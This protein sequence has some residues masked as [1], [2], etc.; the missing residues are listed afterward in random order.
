MVW[1]IFYGGKP[2]R[3][4]IAA[5]IAMWALEGIAAF[6]Q[7]PTCNGKNVY[8]CS[9]GGTLLVLSKPVDYTLNFGS[10]ISAGGG[11]TASVLSDPKNPGFAATATVALQ[12]FGPVLPSLTNYTFSLASVGDQPTIAGVSASIACGVTG[13]AAYSFTLVTPGGPL[14]LKCPHMAGSGTTVT[15]KGQISFAPQKSFALALTLS[16]MA[17]S[18]SDML[19]LGAVSAQV[20][21]PCGSTV[22]PS[23]QAF[24][25]SGGSG[26][27]NITIGPGCAWGVSGIP[28]WVTPTNGASGTGNGKFS[29]QVAADAGADRTA[30][31]TVANISVALE[32]E[33]A[34]IPGL[35]PVGSLAQLASEG[36]WN[37]ELDA[38]NLGS[39]AA[40]VRLDFTDGNGSPLLLPLTF[41]QLAPAPTP[42]LAATL[43]RTIKPNARIVIDSPGPASG[44]TALLGSGQLLSTGSV[45]GF[46]IFSYPALQWNALVP[47]ETRNASTYYLPFDNTGVLATGV[48][49][50]NITA[51][52]TNIQV[53]I[54]NDAGAPI[55]TD[56]I[57]LT[58]QGYQQFMLNARYAQ[59][60]DLRGT[61]QFHTASGGQI[62]VL[63]VRANG[64]ALTTLPV[65][66]N[67][68]SPGGS[69]SQVTY[70]GGFTSTFYLVNTGG[71]PSSFTLSFF[72]QSGNPENVPLS[73]PQSGA[74][75]ST[76]ALTQTLAAGQMLQV[77]TQAQDAA[78]NISGSAQL[79]TT[80][81]I[82]GFEI[83]RWDTYGQE[84]S[85]PLETRTPGSFVLVF[86]NTGGLNT[87]VALANAGASAAN[88]MANI[89]SDEGTLLQTAT[90]KLA[91]RA[92]DLFMLPDFAMGYP[93]TAGRRGM[94]QFVVPPTG[95]IALIGIR[96]NGTTLTTVP[97]LTK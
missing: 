86:D 25:P 93:V 42:E 38:V 39:A 1:C 80:G 72:D 62:S 24:S 29:Y 28:S 96:T 32:Q 51:S 7:T 35:V 49:L 53:T 70:N 40:T 41:P 23:A 65:L 15:V 69:I 44:P 57:D 10:G 88:I 45:S 79:T 97:I 85:V 54:L 73:L 66:S 20:Q 22:S 90:I 19:T 84:A 48:A 74:A 13:A 18:A 63:G 11:G 91:G 68:D 95:P 59:T 33:A 36:G 34:S 75:Q 82:S 58:A 9:V 52:N 26:N 60:T 87:G 47:L 76:S 12:A 14:V 5:G 31:M 30:N 2:L 64:P 46:E 89:Y 4:A 92:Q 83:F 61:I 27:V 43:D 50:A 17:R 21:I 81:N 8:P 37:F 6:A 16:G 94:V 78:A 55:G 3:L 67:V 77:A 56:A 71:A